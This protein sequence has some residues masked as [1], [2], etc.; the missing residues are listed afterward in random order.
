MLRRC[1][2]F[3]FA[4]VAVAIH[5]ALMASPA[6]ADLGC[7]RLGR[8]ACTIL[9]P[10]AAPAHRWVEADAPACIVI[11]GGL[12]SPPTDAFFDPLLADVDTT[13]DGRSF[14]KIRF[15]YDRGDRY[16]YDTYGAID[17]N[18]ASLVSLVRDLDDECFTIDL[19]AHSMGGV[20]VDRAFSM[21]LSSADGVSTYLPL[22]SP[23]NGA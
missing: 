20:V 15:G 6:S 5:A 8:P 4:F 19:V 3:A 1:R 23:H 16:R 14:V 10:V 21:G 17:V 22:A 2:V 11:V 12:G 13:E 7:G 9:R 18:A